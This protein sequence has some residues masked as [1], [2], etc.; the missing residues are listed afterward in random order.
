[1]NVMND[2]CGNVPGVVISNGVRRRRTKWEI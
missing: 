2:E 1:M